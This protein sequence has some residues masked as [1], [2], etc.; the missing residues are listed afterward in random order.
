MDID[1]KDSELY[2]KEI[3]SLDK[4]INIIFGKNGTGK[5]TLVKLIKEQN[6]K[7]DLRIFQGF[8]SVI[9]QNQKLNAVILGEENNEVNQKIKDEEEK[10]KSMKIQGE[11]S[12][13]N[14]FNKK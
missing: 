9:G 5:T 12:T 7:S 11:L 2:E 10:I 4:S 8:E 6:N 13:F 1:L 3:L 14:F